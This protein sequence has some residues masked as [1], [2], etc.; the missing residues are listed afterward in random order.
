VAEA[1]VLEV[2]QKKGK[3]RLVEE[4]KRKLGKR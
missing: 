2:E 4:K 3:G 1:G